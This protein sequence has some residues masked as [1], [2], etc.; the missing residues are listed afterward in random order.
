M[1]YDYKITMSI[2]KYTLQYMQNIRIQKIRMCILYAKQSKQTK[3]HTFKMIR[4]TLYKN[5]YK[6]HKI[7]KYVEKHVINI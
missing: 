3:Y 5:I 7:T 4:S 1:N 2:M 6:I